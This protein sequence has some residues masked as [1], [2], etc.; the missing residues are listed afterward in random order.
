MSQIVKNYEIRGPLGE[1]GM[2]TV[3]YAVNVQLRR[4]VALKRLRHEVANNPDAMDRFRN[5]AQAQAQLNHPNVAHVYEFFQFGAEHYIAMEFVNGSTLAE[6]PSR[7]GRLLH[8]K[9]P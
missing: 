7:A 5:E 6:S 3:Y 2:G 8:A 9:R 4:E 1:G